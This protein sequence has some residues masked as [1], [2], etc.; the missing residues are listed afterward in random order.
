LCTIVKGIALQL[1]EQK[2]DSFVQRIKMRWHRRLVFSLTGMGAFGLAVLVWFYWPAKPDLAGFNPNELGRLETLMW[3]DYY[4][5]DWTALARHTW[6]AARQ[7][8]GFS[9]A[10]SFCLAWHAAWAA[11]SF[12]RDTSDDESVT[13]MAH[14]YRVVGQATSGSFNAAEAARLEVS[15]WRQRRAGVP[16]EEW[17]RTLAALMAAI[18]GQSAECLLPAAQ[19]RVEAMVYR[20]ARRTTGLTDAEWRQV[21]LQL[22]LAYRLLK[23]AIEIPPPEAL[24]QAVTDDCWSSPSNRFFPDSSLTA[25]ASMSGLSVASH[26]LQPRFSGKTAN[27]RQV[28]FTGASQLC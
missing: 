14:Y 10:D 1:K 27:N 15:W 21:E 26:R 9:R 8:Y 4:A 28:S 25:S 20:D 7:Q 2:M 3:R 18:Y 22:C 24:L 19:T 13:A 16:S 6:Q 12:Q 11:R 23:H 5:K 17:S